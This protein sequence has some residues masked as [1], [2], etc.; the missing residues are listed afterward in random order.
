MGLFFQVIT[1]ELNTIFVLQFF[2]WQKFPI[3]KKQK[4]AKKKAQASN[5]KIRFPSHIP[6][7]YHHISSMFS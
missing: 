5:L 2:F 6:P 7:T 3:K 1:F 4:K